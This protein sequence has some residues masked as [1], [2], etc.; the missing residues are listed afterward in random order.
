[1]EE[2]GQCSHCLLPQRQSVTAQGDGEVY[3]PAQLF[4]LL[5]SRTAQSN[6]TVFQASVR[7]G[8]GKETGQGS[9]ASL[10]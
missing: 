5:S 1:M 4:V 7:I 10:K 2:G 8:A 3:M 6:L 9:I